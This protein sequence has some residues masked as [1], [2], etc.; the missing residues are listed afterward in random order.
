MTKLPAIWL[1]IISLFWIG[2]VEFESKAAESR[3]L[4]NARQIEKDIFIWASTH[5][6]EAAVS[7]IFDENRKLNLGG[8]HPTWSFS[9]MIKHISTDIIPPMWPAFVSLIIGGYGLFIR[10]GFKN[11]K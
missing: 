9:M 3:A 10:S 4:S 11:T 6:S 8:E 1:I 2:Y 5:A 7:E